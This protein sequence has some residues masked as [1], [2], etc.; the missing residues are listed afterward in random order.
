[1]SQNPSLK[2]VFKSLFVELFSFSVES[3]YASKHDTLSALET[4]RCVQM[5]LHRFFVFIL[6]HREVV[7]IR[8]RPCL[9]S[10]TE[11][12]ASAML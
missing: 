3:F 10:S 12:Q 4:H 1:M 11:V 8:G 9:V 7:C 2:N 5:L 6:L